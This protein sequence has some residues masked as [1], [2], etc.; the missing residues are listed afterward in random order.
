MK[1]F[2]TLDHQNTVDLDPAM[3]KLI[4]LLPA[5]VV[6]TWVAPRAKKSQILARL[7]FIK[8]WTLGATHV[9]TTN[10]TSYYFRSFML[11]SDLFFS[12]PNKCASQYMNQLAFQLM[13]IPKDFIK[14]GTRVYS[15][16]SAVQHEQKKFSPPQVLKMCKRSDLKIKFFFKTK[17]TEFLTTWIENFFINLYKSAE[18]VLIVRHPIIRIVSAWNDKFNLNNTETN[19]GLAMGMKMLM[20]SPMRKHFPVKLYLVLNFK[21]PYEKK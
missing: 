4:D 6:Y 11:N 9:Y 3:G 21:S 19:V 1:Q 12:V 5:S 10:V 2:Q 17:L 16:R 15:Y 18:K 13:K 7:L 8:L 20:A 14:H